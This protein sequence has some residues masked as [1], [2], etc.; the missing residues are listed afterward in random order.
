MDGAAVKRQL[1]WLLS[2]AFVVLLLIVIVAHNVTR[3]RILVLQSYGTE[4]AWTRDVDVGIRRVF[5]DTGVAGNYELRWHYMDLKRHP[6]PESKMAAG[7]QARHAIDEWRPDVLIAVDD[8]AQE[9]AAKYYANRPDIRIVFAGTNGS[10]SPYGY[11][12]AD[13]VTGILERKPLTAIRDAL[14]Q[15]GF[16]RNGPLRI[17]EICDA[18]ETV[19]L[20]HASIAAFDWKPLRYVGAH[21]VETFD[22]W[23]RAVLAADGEADVIMTTN[24]RKLSRSHIDRT[25]VPPDEV[26]AWTEQHSQLPVIGTNAF[27]VEDGG[28]LAIATSPFEQG[29]TAAR[30]ARQIIDRGTSPRD[31]AVATTRQYIVLARPGLLARHHLVLPSLY[32]AFARATNNYFEEA[33]DTAA[34]PKGGK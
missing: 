2:G 6:W 21:L 15:I 1:S 9:Y 4:Y 13:N 18:S 27:F 7:V 5:D 11:D 29:E 32:E 28:M 25:L 30:M 34:V 22:D 8:D 33:D 17:V 10:I 26:L 3:P 16:A 19:K 23:Q 20:D 14:I 12:K 31:I 24:Y